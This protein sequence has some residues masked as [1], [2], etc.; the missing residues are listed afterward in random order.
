MVTFQREICECPG[1]FPVNQHTSQSHMS[2]SALTYIPLYEKQHTMGR[3]IVLLTLKWPRLQVKNTWSIVPVR[4]SILSLT[5]SLRIFHRS[6]NT[7]T[8][9]T[10]RRLNNWCAMVDALGTLFSIP[11]VRAA[12]FT[13]RC[14][15]LT[16]LIQLKPAISGCFALSTPTFVNEPCALICLFWEY[17]DNSGYSLFARCASR[18]GSQ[19]SSTYKYAPLGLTWCTIASVMNSAIVVV[20]GGSSNVSLNHADFKLVL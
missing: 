20:P 12:G 4:C 15:R 1:S 10:Y 8:I 14:S 5:S 9:V 18:R 16:V 17:N 3:C 13:I 6:H 2:F 11:G 19:T 7:H